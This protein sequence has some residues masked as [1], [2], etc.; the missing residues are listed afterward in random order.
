[1]LDF[2]GSIEKKYDLRIGNIF[3]AGDGNLHPL[4]MY[5]ERNREQTARVS[6]AAKDIIM[7]CVE[8]GGSITGEHGVGFEKSDLMPLIFSDDDLEL[9]SRVKNLFNPL[10]RL[11][12]GKLLPTGKMC[13]E[14]RG[15][16][17]GGGPV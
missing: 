2:I 15:G 9:M 1:M 11:N 12:P 17:A 6:K 7:R 4:I 8:M 5:D 13:G 16:L 14:L 10:G 3:H